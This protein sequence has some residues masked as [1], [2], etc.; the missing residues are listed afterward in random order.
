MAAPLPELTEGFRAQLRFAGSP[1]EWAGAVERALGEDSPG[2]RDSRIEIARA[3]TW[4]S[5]YERI[6]ALL[7]ELDAAAVSG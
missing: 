4:E 7:A 5:R 6:C 3:N 1:A 2:A